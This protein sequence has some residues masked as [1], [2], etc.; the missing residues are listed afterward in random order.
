VLKLHSRTITHKSDVGGVKLNLEDKA[1]VINAFEEIRLSAKE[2]FEGVTVQPMIK[3][4]GYE[5]I[6]GSYTDEQFGPVIL[7]GLGGELVEVFKDKA[8][9]MAPL[10]HFLAKELMQETRIYKALLGVRGRPAVDMEALEKIL[11]HFSRMILEL[12]MIKECD[13]NPLIVSSKEILALD[14]RVVLHR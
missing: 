9:S 3:L 6:V 2:G 4:K 14:A 12:P 8:L 11:I 1:A 13:I 10:N 5:L 7:F